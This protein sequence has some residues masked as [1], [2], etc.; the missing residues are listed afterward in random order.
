MQKNRFVHSQ[1]APEDAKAESGEFQSPSDILFSVTSRASL[2]RPG[3]H[4]C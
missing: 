2:S 3:V 4:G 1:K